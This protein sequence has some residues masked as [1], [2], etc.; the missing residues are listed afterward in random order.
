MINLNIKDSNRLV[1]NKLLREIIKFIIIKIKE[2]WQIKNKMKYELYIQKIHM[3]NHL[4][5]LYRDIIIILQQHIIKYQI[6]NM[7]NKLQMNMVLTNIQIKEVIIMIIL[8]IEE[9]MIL[10]IIQVLVNHYIDKLKIVINLRNQELLREYEFQLHL[11][12]NV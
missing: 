7:I 1:M 11:K 6:W 3:K 2:K 5:V 12:I 9:I 8:K 10:I 4:D